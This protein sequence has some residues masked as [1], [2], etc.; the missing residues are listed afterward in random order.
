VEYDFDV[1]VANSLGNVEVTMWITHRTALIDTASL[2]L[3][4]YLTVT[5]AENAMF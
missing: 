2:L 5:N 3:S 4:R 1:T